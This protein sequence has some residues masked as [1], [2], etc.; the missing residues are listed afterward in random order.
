MEQVKTPALTRNHWNWLLTA[1]GTVDETESWFPEKINETAGPCAGPTRAEEKGSDGQ[2]RARG[3]A[4]R[5]PGWH[6]KGDEEAALSSAAQDER[7][8]PLEGTACDIAGK[9]AELWE[10]SAPT[11]VPRD[12]PRTQCREPHGHS[13]KN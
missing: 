5:T 6:E 4:Y 11:H 3:R 1:G 7:P 12:S 8:S 10:A 9:A 13:A 2:C